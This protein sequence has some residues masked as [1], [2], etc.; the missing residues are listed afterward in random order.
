MNLGDMPDLPDGLPEARSARPMAG[1]DVAAVWD[2]TLMDGR[3]VVVKTG[4]GDPDLEAEGLQALAAAGAPTPAVLAQSDR[5]LVLEYVDGPAAGWEELGRALASV[6]R[7]SS[8]RFGW[9]RD[10]LIGSLPQANDATT[11]WPE[12]YLEYRLRPWLAC[13]PGVLRGRLERA[14]ARALPA[15]LERDVVP[16]LVHGDLWSGNVVAGRWLIDP[17]VHYADRE[18]DFAML[19][20]FGSIPASMQAGYD[21]I[22]PL[23][24]GWQERRPALQIYHLLVH[25]R[26]FG[27]SYCGAVSARLDALGV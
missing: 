2:V 18:L 1:G 22:W 4:G 10:N 6:H 11:N 14:M 17:A 20:L 25:V 15:L 16:S 26:L 13:L 24:P 9:H 23:D 12:F 3:R 7:A 8:D 27:S 21:A 19:D 5:T